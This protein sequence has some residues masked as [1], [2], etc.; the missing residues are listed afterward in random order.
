MYKVKDYLYNGLLFMNNMLRPH[1]KKLSQLMIYATTQC[2]SRC[3]YILID[4]I[5]KFT[6][7]E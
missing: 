7:N 4:A 1:N 2:Q 3:T 5:N 6:K